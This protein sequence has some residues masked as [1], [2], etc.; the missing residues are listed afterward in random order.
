MPTAP[1]DVNN[2]PVPVMPMR[3]VA[4]GRWLTLCRTLCSLHSK[5]QDRRWQRA[6]KVAVAPGRW[7]APCRAGAPFEC[8]GGRVVLHKPPGAAHHAP[9]DHS[10]GL[11][12]VLQEPFPRAPHLIIVAGYRGEL[13]SRAKRG[14]HAEPIATRGRH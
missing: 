10:H 14:G 1:A 8:S 6:V 13:N 7:Q 9:R 11:L 4:S 3:M 2:P 12:P 5:G